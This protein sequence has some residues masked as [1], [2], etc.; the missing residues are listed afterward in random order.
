[1]ILRRCVFLLLAWSLAAMSRAAEPEVS[2][3]FPVRPGATFTLDSHRGSVTVTEG[4]EPEIRVLV[5]LAVDA[6]TEEEA[7]RYRA[8]LQLD[9]KAEGNAVAVY[10]RDRRSQGPKFVWQ[11]GHEM[12]LDFRITVPR[13]CDVTIRLREGGVTIGNLSGRMAAQVEQGSIFFRQIDGSIQAST[14]S[15]DI[16]ISRCLGPVTAQ[17]DRGMIRLG[18]ILGEASLRNGSGDIEVMTAKGG[19]VAEAVAG[20]ISV[21]FARELNARSRLATSGGSI[22]ATLHEASACTV[23]AS[24]VWGKVRSELALTTDSGK[25]G[26]RKFAGRLN[27]GGPVLEFHANGG[28]VQLTGGEAPFD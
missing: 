21:G 20:D 18:T 9:M 13:R 27:G 11:E 8:A 2:R 7:A 19:V 25:N 12:D 5:G 10:G 28:N 23:Q 3:T 24:T 6:D 15:G 1:M 4:D 16:T 17:V 26:S 14:R 22:F